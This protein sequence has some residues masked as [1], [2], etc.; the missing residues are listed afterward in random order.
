[1]EPT[2]KLAWSDRASEV[3]SKTSYPKKKKAGGF[4]TGLKLFQFF[5]ESERENNIYHLSA[6]PWLL[7]V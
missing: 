1:M 3:G 7:Q 5:T 4:P 2:K 6:V